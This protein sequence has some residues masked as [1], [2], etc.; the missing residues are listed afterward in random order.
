M[1]SDQVTEEQLREVRE[2][3]ERVFKLAKKRT[4]AVADSFFE[5][6]RRGIAAALEGIFTAVNPK[7]RDA[8]KKGWVVHHTLP[9]S[10]L[11]QTEEENL[12][13]A[14][15]AYYREKWVDVR[16]IIEKNTDQYLVD[17]DSKELMRQALEAHERQLYSLVPRSLLPEIEAVIR[18]HLHANKVGS[19]DMKSEISQFGELPASWF[20]DLSSD[21]IQYEILE[22]H[23]YEG[24]HTD[25]TR[26]KFAESPIPNRHATVHGL[27]TYSSEKSSLNS[28]FLTDFTLYMITAWK[29]AWIQRVIT[30]INNHACLMK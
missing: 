8:A 22:D 10:L 6:I 12:D 25:A 11:E 1:N 23:L 21:L 2:S 17:E 7:D 14:I 5:S 3:F 20:R 18:R 16:G 4:A 29:K 13:A 28:I 9:T 30:T 19:L 27:V 26:G 24:I 15:M